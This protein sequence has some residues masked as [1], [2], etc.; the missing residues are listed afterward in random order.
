MGDAGVDF[1]SKKTTISSFE[2]AYL[3]EHW[4]KSSKIG[5]DCRKLAKLA[6][7]LQR[8]QKIGKNRQKYANIAENR[9]KSP[10]IVIITLAPD[11]P[12]PPFLQHHRHLHLLPD[13]V[14]ALADPGRQSPRRDRRKISVATIVHFLTTWFAPRCEFGP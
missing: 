13:S 9:H 10:K 2:N 4:Q 12:V 1:C 8:L 14:H 11:R 3:A 6:E 7:N 5:K